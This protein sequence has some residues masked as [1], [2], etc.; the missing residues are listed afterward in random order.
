MENI[1]LKKISGLILSL[2]LSWALG[3]QVNPG[4]A[5]N[6]GVVDNHDVLYISY[7]FGSVGPRRTDT[8]VSTETPQAINQYWTEN[9]PTGQ[10]YIFADADGN[11]L[12]DWQDVLVVYN[13]YGFRYNTFRT[14]SYPLGIEGV[15]PKLDLALE[16]SLSLITEGTA[17][18]IPLYLG[19]LSLPIN[20]F[21][22][23]A[24]SIIFDSSYVREAR[25]E[26]DSSAWLTEDGSYISFQNA[27]PGRSG[28]LDVAI[29]RLGQNPLTGS[30][31]IGTLS[32]IIEDDLVDFRPLL[33]D[34]VHT[35]I[36]LEKIELIDAEF[37]QLPIVG[38]SLKI[39]I[40]NPALVSPV[41]PDFEPLLSIY[42]NPA[43]DW[44][45]V[46]C[47]SPIDGIELW[48]AQGRLL[49]KRDVG[50]SGN[51]RITLPKTPRKLLILKI[52]T[53]KG[54]LVRKLT[55]H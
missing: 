14:T 11:G 47:S 41:P 23:L 42:P 51:Y 34:S 26:I 24:F 49:L 55:T 17:V 50:R 32:I 35:Q 16:D 10:N 21:N 45:G 22:G 36:W 28:A 31:F 3:A 7:A 20:E 54:V 29:S 6:N 30:G 44:I 38:D 25:L 1:C 27:P 2:L 12:V 15:D 46:E 53:T 43:K 4:D 5:D 52:Y 33:K 39:K 48:D 8:D 37:N 9:F 40:V 18:K 13:N 19:D